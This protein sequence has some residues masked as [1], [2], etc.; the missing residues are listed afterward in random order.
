MIAQLFLLSIQH[1]NSQIDFKTA[2]AMLIKQCT[3][4]FSQSDLKVPVIH[5]P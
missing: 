3:G 2:M 4:P 1:K 5:G